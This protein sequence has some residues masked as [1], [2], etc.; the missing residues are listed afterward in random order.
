MSA[1]IEDIIKKT[2]WNESDEAN[3]M[4]RKMSNG[5]QRFDK[6]KGSMPLDKGAMMVECRCSNCSSC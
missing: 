3:A 6:S 4:W 1:F 5:I 2:I